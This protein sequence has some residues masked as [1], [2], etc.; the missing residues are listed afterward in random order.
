MLGKKM[1][2]LG[3][4][5]ESTVELLLRTVVSVLGEI[6]VGRHVVGKFQDRKML[7][8]SDVCC[9][10]VTLDVSASQVGEMER[11]N[12]FSLIGRCLALSAAT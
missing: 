5:Q 9:V 11:S 2:V 10:P 3:H 12:L 6:H 1:D 8:A 4:L 7:C